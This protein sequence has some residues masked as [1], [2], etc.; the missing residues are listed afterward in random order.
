MVETPL[1]IILFEGWCVGVKP[2]ANEELRKP[3]NILEESDDPKAVWRSHVN[4]QLAT[5]YAN[6][7][8]AIDLLIMLEIPDMDCVSA[9]RGLQEKKL[10]AQSQRSDATKL[11]D[12]AALNRFIMHYERLTRSMLA[13]MPDRADLVF[14]LN[15]SHQIDG[16]QINNRT[17]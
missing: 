1:D 3:V 8:A 9:W 13:E 17:L 2:Q 6:L 11:M 10:A 12:K 14:E 16:V 4:K 7:F 15:Q 5:D